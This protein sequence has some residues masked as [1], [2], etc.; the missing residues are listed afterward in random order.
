MDAS[1][2]SFFNVF[3][4]IFWSK[5][6]ESKALCSLENDNHLPIDSNVNVDVVLLEGGH[7]F[8]SL[9][10]HVAGRTQPDRVDGGLLVHVLQGGLQLVQAISEVLTDEIVNL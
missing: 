5:D 8:H 7:V 9:D 3:N 2:I 6:L 4:L 1:L 10:D